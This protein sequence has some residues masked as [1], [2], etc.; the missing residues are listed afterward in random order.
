MIDSVCTIVIQPLFS[1]IKMSA[2]SRMCVC[3]YKTTLH[4]VNCLTRVYAVAHY[5]VD[6]TNERNTYRDINQ[7]GKQ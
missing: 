5:A 1:L 4:R 2:E 3:V 6:I 7:K